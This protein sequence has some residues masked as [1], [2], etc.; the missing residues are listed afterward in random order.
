MLVNQ[1]LRTTVP[2]PV[3]LIAFSPQYLR[4]NEPLPFGVRD[5]SGRLLLSAGKTI[6][7]RA[8]LEELAKQALFADEAES[9]DWNRRLA[10]A[11]DQMIRQG[12]SL[13][14]VVAARPEGPAREAATPTLQTLTEQWQDLVKQLDS[15]LREVRAGSDWRNRLFS[16][17]ARSRLLAQKRLDASLY[18]LVYEAGHSTQKYSCHH[19]LLTLLICE[20]AAPLLG[21]SPA[22]TDSVGRA[23]LCMNVSMLRLQDQ[24]AASQL[25]PTSAMRAE[26]DAHAGASARQL[27]DA[28]L[29]DPLACAVVAL[30]HDASMADVPLA[31]LEPERQL[32]RLLRRVDIFVAKISRRAS[33]APMS[34]VQAAREACLGALGV[35]DEIGGALLKAVGLYPPGSFVELASGE[36]GIVVARGRRANLPFVASLVSASGSP[37]GEPTLRDTLDS[38]YT[39]R[40]AVAPHLVKV[41][42]QHERLFALR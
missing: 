31:G 25:A 23:A 35:P 32:G 19:A 13:K 8:S 27:V 39:V 11:M 34:P 5:A 2:L 20:Q 1:D 6:D 14:D 42:P 16:V 40:A 15:A 33:R 41:R 18:H 24:L 7:S 17:H 9:A 36:I 4:L 21:W 3:K 30:H 38:R 22:W 37:L 26:I 10:A 12:A 28:G 29:G